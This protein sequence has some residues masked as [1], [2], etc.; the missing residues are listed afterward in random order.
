MHG[1]TFT[2]F[3]FISIAI[4]IRI[5]WQRHL[6]NDIFSRKGMNYKIVTRFTTLLDYP[7]RVKILVRL[8]GGKEWFIRISICAAMVWRIIGI[9][10]RG[11]L[12]WVGGR[13]QIPFSCI[14]CTTPHTTRMPIRTIVVSNIPNSSLSPRLHAP[15]T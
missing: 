8:V 13:H 9:N 4:C 14:R 3:S 10:S 2:I 12:L 6:I 11:L 1:L 15:K 7:Y 5:I